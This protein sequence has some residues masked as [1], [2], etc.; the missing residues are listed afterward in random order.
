MTD[1]PLRELLIQ[2]LSLVGDMAR[3]NAAQLQNRQ[4]LGGRE[5]ALALAERDGEGVA[6]AAFALAREEV[7]AAAGRLAAVE[8]ELA[9]LGARLDAIDARIAVL[10]VPPAGDRSVRSGE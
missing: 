9:E 1:N 3:L 5:L 7:A 8:A 6:D 4:V 2:R 10:N